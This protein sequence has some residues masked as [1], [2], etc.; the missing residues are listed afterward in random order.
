[1]TAH[2]LA[3][4]GARRVVLVRYLPD[5][6]GIAAGA[7]RT[8]HLIPLPVRGDAGAFNALCE[9]RLGAELIET[10]TPGE[11][12]PCALCFVA[13]LSGSATQPAP[14]S[15]EVTA[16]PLLAAA[17][18]RALGWPVSVHREQVALRL[19]G[20]AVALIIPTTLAAKVTAI[21]ATRRCPAPVLAHPQAPAHRI[22]LAGEPFG[23]PLP[24]PDE[25]RTATGAVLLPPT[26]TPSGPITWVELPDTHML[27]YCREIDVFG[28]VHTLAQSQPCG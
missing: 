19:D 2:E 27:A 15:I 14:D 25:V 22:V 5:L 4:A 13:H 6:P 11:G 23:V 28:A 17:G 8:V 3:T 18:Y 10:V 20:D 1:M 7:V 24:W 21:L 16:G 26:L 12:T 9:L